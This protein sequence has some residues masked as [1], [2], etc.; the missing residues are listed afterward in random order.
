MIGFRLIS[1]LSYYSIFLYVIPLYYYSLAYLL[2]A[3]LPLSSICLYIYVMLLSGDPWWHICPLLLVG[4]QFLLH[5]FRSLN[6]HF[7]LLDVWLVLHVPWYISWLTW[8]NMCLYCS[9]F[10]FLLWGGTCWKV[11]CGFLM[12]LFVLNAC[13]LICGWMIGGFFIPSWG[14]QW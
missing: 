5:V 7:Y 2:T 4:Q 1:L 3:F 12:V 11:L 6:V 8:C 14:K 10:F 13:D 9:W